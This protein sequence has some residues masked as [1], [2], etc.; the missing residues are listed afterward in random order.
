MKFL[1][2]SDWKF[3]LR[4]DAYMITNKFQLFQLTLDQRPSAEPGGVKKALRGGRRH[5]LLVVADLQKEFWLYFI[6]F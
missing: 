1:S 5:A 2:Q 4:G 3:E 6:L